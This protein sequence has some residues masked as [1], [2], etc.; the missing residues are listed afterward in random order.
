MRSSIRIKNYNKPVFGVQFSNRCFKL[1]RSS[2]YG[3]H[4]SVFVVFGVMATLIAAATASAESIGPPSSYTSCR[5]T[6]Q[7]LD[8]DLNGAALPENICLDEFGEGWA[9]AAP[10]LDAIFALSDLKRGGIGPIGWCKHTINNCS[11]WTTSNR[12]SDA[13][14]CAVARRPTN[15][16]G[17]LGMRSRELCNQR[18]PIWCCQEKPKGGLQ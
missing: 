5:M 17:I 13:T 12:G 10:R 7:A 2:N 16:T 6:K 15:N 9:F 3:P 11:G 14:V 18:H 1:L 8:G 4:A